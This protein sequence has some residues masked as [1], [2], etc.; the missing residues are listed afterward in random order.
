MH[1]PR[2]DHRESFYFPIKKKHAIGTAIP[3]SFCPGL[4]CDVWIS[5]RIYFVASTRKSMRKKHRV[6]KLNYFILDFL[7]WK[8]KSLLFYVIVY[9]TCT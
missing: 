9:K 3:H 5:R 7:F 2:E 6:T 1:G 8:N 4:D